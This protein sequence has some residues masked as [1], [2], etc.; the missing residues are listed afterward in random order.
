[1]RQSAG[2][3]IDSERGA[4]LVEFALLL[5]MILLLVFGIIEFAGTYNN[6]ISLRN[7]VREGARL[8]VVNNVSPS[9]SCSG[10]ATS[11]LVCQT[12]AR[13][14]LNASSTKVAITLPANAKVVD[15]V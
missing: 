10:G 13:V 15:S 6:S 5:P 14:G 1:M 7:G 9:G 8:A 4:A 3:R 11:V 12:K 2:T